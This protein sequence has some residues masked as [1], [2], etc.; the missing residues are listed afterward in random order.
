MGATQD[1]CAVISLMRAEGNILLTV[2]EPLRSCQALREQSGSIQEPFYKAVAVGFLRSHMAFLQLAPV[3]V[4]GM[5]PGGY[6]QEDESGHDS[7]DI[8]FCKVAHGY[9]RWHKTPERGF[10]E[11]MMNRV[12]D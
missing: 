5:V 6:E 8:L 7:V 1:V 2:M 3:G 10:Y 9:S 4:L 11:E 12:G